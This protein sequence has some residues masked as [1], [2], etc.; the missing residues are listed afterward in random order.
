MRPDLRRE[1]YAGEQIEYKSYRHFNGL[2]I[3]AH[4]FAAAH[5][6]SWA[7][8][9]TASATTLP[10]QTCAGAQICTNDDK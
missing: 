3:H 10:G 9:G 1:H 8:G 5:S 7:D 6:R 2:L 4:T